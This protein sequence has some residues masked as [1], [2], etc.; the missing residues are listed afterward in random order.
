MRPATKK[1]TLAS[2]KSTLRAT[3]LE[4]IHEIDSTSQLAHSLFDIQL[5]NPSIHA[6]VNLEISF[7]ITI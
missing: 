4:H 7:A 2:P 3:Q 5:Y 6:G 1:S